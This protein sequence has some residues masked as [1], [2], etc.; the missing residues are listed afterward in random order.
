MI[1][2]RRGG[3]VTDG[4]Q[5]VYPTLMQ[6]PAIDASTDPEEVIRILRSVL[7]SIYH[8]TNNPLSIVSGNAQYF[9]EL[10]KAMEVDEDLVQPVRD[11]EEGAERVAAGLRRLTDLRPEIEAYLEARRNDGP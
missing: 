6:G 1:C 11:I 4:I 2:R 3:L 7:S 5:R 9:L 10:S 8:D